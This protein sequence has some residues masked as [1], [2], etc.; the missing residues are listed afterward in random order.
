MVLVYADTDIANLALSHIGGGTITDLDERTKE[1][2]LV[3]RFFE[4]ARLASLEK[5]DWSFARKHRILADSDSYPTGEWVYAYDLPLD[6]VAPRLILPELA[7]GERNPFTV[8]A[9]DDGARKI[10]MT[11]ISEATLKYTFD[12][13][14]NHMFTPNFVSHFSH[15]LASLIAY[16]QTKKTGLLQAQIGLANDASDTAQGVDAN[17][18]QQEKP[19]PDAAWITA[20]NS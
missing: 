2:R 11:D 8:E 18:N 15:R 3:K 14:N 1:A 16:N 10:L 5:Y 9:S 13:K 20:R 17:V 4:I 19:Q 6:C 7:Q 12:Q